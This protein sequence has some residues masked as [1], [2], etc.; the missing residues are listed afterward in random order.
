MPLEFNV[1][2]LEKKDLVLEGELPSSELDLDSVDELI[3]PDKNLTYRLDVESLEEGILVRGEILFKLHCECSRCLKPF[4]FELSFPDWSC[5]LPLKGEDA[6]VVRNDSVD[7]TP[8]LR[9]DIL[10]GFPQHPLCRD[11]CPGLPVNRPKSKK[12]KVKADR[13]SEGQNPSTWSALD[14]LQF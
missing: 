9:E 7:L 11:D 6:V 12:D 13:T 2:H 10:L 1:R 5:H 14:K 4:D 8:Y 3:H